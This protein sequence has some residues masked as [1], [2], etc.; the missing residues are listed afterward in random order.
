MT[1][2]ANDGRGEHGASRIRSLLVV[3]LIVAAGAVSF[4]VFGSEIKAM[5]V[6]I[7]DRIAGA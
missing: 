6:A 4:T 2:S 3:V 1:W 5:F 7:G